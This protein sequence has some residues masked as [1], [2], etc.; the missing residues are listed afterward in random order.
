MV[1]IPEALDEHVRAFGRERGEEVVGGAVLRDGHTG[2][3]GLEQDGPV[4][5]RFGVEGL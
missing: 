1:V 2:W 4:V 3:R 5:K